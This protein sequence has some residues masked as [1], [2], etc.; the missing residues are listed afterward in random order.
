M[1]ILFCSALSRRRM[2]AWPHRPQLNRGGLQLGKARRS[3]KSIFRGIFHSS[4]LSCIGAL[5]ILQ[6]I[7]LIDMMRKGYFL[8]TK[9]N[10][11][12]LSVE[13]FLTVFALTYFLLSSF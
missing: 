11:I 2:W 3:L 13:M 5:I 8:G 10:P 4:G 1:L 12:I 6:L 9:E 7:V